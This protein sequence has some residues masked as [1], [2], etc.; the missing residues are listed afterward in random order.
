MGTIMAKLWRFKFNICGIGFQCQ[1]TNEKLSVA[2]KKAYELCADQV[3]D[4]YKSEALNGDYLT[5]I[6][7]SKVHLIAE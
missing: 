7:L 6:N 2:E 4:M 1:V 5:D 3:G